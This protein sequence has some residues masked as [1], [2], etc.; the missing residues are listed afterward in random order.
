MTC[1]ARKGKVRAQPLVIYP[2][3]VYRVRE[4]GELVEEV[5]FPLVMRC[6]FPDD[7]AHLFSTRGFAIV[8]SWGGY[9]GETYGAG[10]E[11]VIQ[12]KPAV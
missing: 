4:G 11:L 9:A 12:A 1:H 2:E 5:V 3:L 7:F 10:P 8:E 6:Y